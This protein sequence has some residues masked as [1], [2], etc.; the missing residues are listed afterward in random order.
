M[1]TMTPPDAQRSREPAITSSSAKKAEVQQT[2]QAPQ[3]HRRDGLAITRSP[4]APHPVRRWMHRVGFPAA[5]VVFVVANVAIIT[6]LWLNHG[7]LPHR[8]SAAN[9]YLALGQLTA[10]YGT[11]AA[12]V[13]VL[14]MARVPWLDRRF[15]MDRLAKWHKWTG[16]SLAWT[17]LAHVIFSTMGWAIGDGKGNI[18]EFLSLNATENTVLLATIGFVLLAV[19]AFSSVRI[20]RRKLSYELW[21]WVHLL[22]YVMLV[23]SF[24]HIVV[25]GSDFDHHKWNTR[26]WVVLYALM[27]GAVV[28]HRLGGPM[29]NFLRHSF[30]VGGVTNEAEGVASLHITG[31]R[32]DRLHI[33]AGQFVIVRFLSRGWWFKAHP[34]SVSGVRPGSLRLTVKDLGN[35][36]G[37]I[38]RLHVGTRVIVEGP[39]GAFTQ[40]ARS[41]KRVFLIAG[42]IGITPIR[43]LFEQL[44]G[45]PGD[46]TL[47]Y[48]APAEDHL[49]FRDELDTIAAIRG[50][51]VHYVCG[52]RHQHDAVFDPENLERIAPGLTE[53]DVY[54]CG[55]TD[56]VHAAK[57]GLRDAGVKANRIHHED[58][59]L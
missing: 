19:V 3:S 16:F 2:Y 21:F 50:F 1:D 33:G 37:R 15:G 39:Y 12:L 14:L 40:S 45:G 47:L 9:V 13:Q 55:P 32:L 5:A 58:F 23:V 57:R 48:R 29:R 53:R 41:K 17:L 59:A 44:H 34:F 11:F 51:D 46:V 31:K 27:V 4:F 43:A 42:G 30:Q 28:V 38:S 35:D 10:L 26:Y 24:P 49:L 22:A 8:A 36:S 7:G 52:S 6:A 56:M 25:L 54:I 20:A 18:G